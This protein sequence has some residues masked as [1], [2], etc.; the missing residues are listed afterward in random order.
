MFVTDC[1]NCGEGVPAFAQ[2]CPHCG[3]ANRARP[4]AFAIVGAIAFLVVVVA[5]TTI[6]ILHRP[7][8]ETALE[9]PVAAPGAPAQTPAAADF[10]WLRTAM[11]GCEAD[12]SKE[13][14]TLHFLVIPLAAGKD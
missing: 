6:L 10:G 14:S 1:S 8:S 3:A 13:S 12:A 2:K 7:A 5:V 4:A 11:D 9:T